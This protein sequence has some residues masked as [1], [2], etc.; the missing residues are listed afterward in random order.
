MSFGRIF[1]FQERYALEIRAEFTNIFNRTVL[2]N[3]TSTNAGQAKVF[4]P[5]TGLPSSGFGFINTTQA[6]TP[7]Q[8]MI[9]ARFK[10]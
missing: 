8:G 6:G 10:F 9:V 2:P 5:A 1:R 3:P 4:D 7:R